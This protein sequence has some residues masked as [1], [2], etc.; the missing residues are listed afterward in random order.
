[1]TESTNLS[2]ESVVERVL[3]TTKLDKSVYLV[4]IDKVQKRRSGASRP[5]RR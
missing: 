4:V 1:L 2:W 5:P 3:A